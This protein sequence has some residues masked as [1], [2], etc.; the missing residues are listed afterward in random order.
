MSLARYGVPADLMAGREAEAAALAAQ[1][2]TP[3]EERAKRRKN[4]KHN[5]QRKLHVGRPEDAVEYDEDEDEEGE[6]D[7]VPLGR[8]ASN[9]AEAYGPG[10]VRAHPPPTM[11]LG[12]YKRAITNILRDFLAVGDVEACL[13]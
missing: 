1:I 9:E 2:K 5:P 3:T 8:S 4:T 7:D 11:S 12:D 13:T 6:D 10:A